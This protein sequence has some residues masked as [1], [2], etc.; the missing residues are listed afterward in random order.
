M[1]TFKSVNKSWRAGQV[2]VEALLVV[3]I[4]GLLI[5]G[6]IELSR[7]VAVRQALDSGTG[8][9]TRALSLDPAQ[10]GFA[11][12]LV[13]QSVNQNVMGTQPPVTLQVYDTSN[14]PRS[15][16]WLSGS[17]FGTSFVIEAAVPFQADIPFLPD[18]AVMIRVRH[19]GIVERY[20]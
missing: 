2:A 17:P 13:Q 12:N 10:W 5:F 16:V 20:P 9:A 15:S 3:I 19:W 7:G 11:N 6:G 1:S 14:M 4:F 18:S 8:A